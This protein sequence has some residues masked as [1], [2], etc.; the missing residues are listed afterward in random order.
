M[1]PA[2]ALM[3][4]TGA[5]CGAPGP[6]R[7][8]R[9]ALIGGGS[10]LPFEL[11]VGDCFDDPGPG[12]VETV[13]VMPCEGEHDF[14]VYHRFMLPDGSYPGAQAIQDAWI[15]GCLA[16]FEL[17]VGTSFDESMLDISGIYPT[18]ESWEG[19]DDREVLCSVTAVNGQPR[20]GS[21][22]GSGV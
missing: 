1:A 12:E 6:A 16:E 14:E 10:L 22:Q 17:F 7:D 21:A 11:E 20:A 9:G 19:I 13:M 4:A 2:V 8:D 18:R 15:E 3:V 5:A